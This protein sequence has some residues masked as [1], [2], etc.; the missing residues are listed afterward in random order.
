MDIPQHLNELK[1][2]DV[3]LSNNFFLKKLL[4]V[5]RISSRSSV[6]QVNM[7]ELTHD[8]HTLICKAADLL[9][10]FGTSAFTNL[11]ELR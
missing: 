8:I 2:Y 10:G 1:K 11:S 6:T 5:P 4:T 9:L 3:S 7:C